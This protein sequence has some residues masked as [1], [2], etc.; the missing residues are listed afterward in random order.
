M[1]RRRAKIPWHLLRWMVYMIIIVV[2]L[3][4][5][6]QT[7]WESLKRRLTSPA[8]GTGQ[9]RLAGDDL[10]PG[11]IAGLVTFYGRDYPDLTIELRG[12]GTTPALEDLANGRAD[13][14]F[15]YRPPTREESAIFHA[16]RVDSIVVHRVALAPVLLLRS[17]AAAD[18]AVSRTSLDAFLRTGRTADFARLYAPDPNTG[19]W[20][21]LL[22][23]LGADPDQTRHGVV[24]LADEASVIEAT[25]ADSVAVGVVSGFTHAFDA[26]PDGLRVLTVLFADGPARPDPISVATARYRLHHPLLAAS[27]RAGSVEGAMFVTHLTS[28]RGQR[29]VE[30]LGF[31][32]ARR[33]LRE[34]ILTTEPVGGSL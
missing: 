22:D 18:T 7:D 5:R 2:L 10:A 3:L 31:L 34:I 15:L 30:R 33:V 1:E 4:V 20:P 16:A 12:G 27:L 24:F 19:L 25:R 32:P 26:P 14:A 17:T 11:L 28:G 21:A 29:Q 8:P 9:L 13:V 6:D 23:S